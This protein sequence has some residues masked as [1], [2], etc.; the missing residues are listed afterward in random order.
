MYSKVVLQLIAFAALLPGAEVFTFEAPDYAAS[1]L[2]MWLPGQQGWY[3][4][5]ASSSDTSVYPYVGNARGFVTNPSGGQQFAGGGGRT[6]HAF[7][8]SASPL[9]AIALDIAMIKRPDSNT[10]LG[11][12]F[13]LIDAG[14]SGFVTTAVS[15]LNDPNDPN[16]TWR[17]G[18][19]G[20]GNP[21]PGFLPGPAWDGLEQNHWYRTG[22]T[23]DFAN[24]RL[25]LAWILDPSTG[26]Y[27]QYSFP[28]LEFANGLTPNA[29]R[30][31]GA[32]GISG[33]DNITLQAVPEPATF[34]LLG[35]GLAAIGVMKR[36]AVPGLRVN[37]S[38]HLNAVGEDAAAWRL[39][40]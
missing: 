29:I 4:P 20:Q 38:N 37:S 17:L 8:F 11:G 23:V 28:N 18:Y 27:A 2:G 6:E 32:G 16:S 33:W 39:V 24:R 10:D 36:K 1:D 40:K 34:L 9:W 30:V 13:S 31:F 21:D 26:D 15:Y 22:M 14:P 25:V 19:T 5:P 7:D 35:C 12:R 3:V